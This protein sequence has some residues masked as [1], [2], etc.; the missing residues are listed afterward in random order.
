MAHRYIFADEPMSKLAIWARRMAFFSLTAVFVSILIVRSELL[1]IGP[2]LTSF[3][4]ALV[5][6]V[7][8]LVLSAAAL[9]VIW[10]DGL[11]GLGRT[12][13]AI[14]IAVAL[15]AYPLYL[16]YKAYKLP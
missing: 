13:S 14:G 5:P 4:V 10:N 1:D 11:R 6:A 15:L 3:A 2:A 12:F 16:S 7:L 9:V 8:A